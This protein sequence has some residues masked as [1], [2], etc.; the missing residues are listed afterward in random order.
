MNNLRPTKLDDIVGQEQVV[1][2]LNIAIN[3]AKS[4][5]AAL[6]H[7]LF[8]GGPGLGKTSLACAVA[9]TRGVNILI[10][11]GGNIRSIKNI[12]PYLMKLGEN[13]ILFIDEIHR[14]PRVVE[15]FL[16]PCMEDFRMDM[17]DDAKSME[18]P[19]FTMIGATTEMGS[20]ARPFKDRFTYQFQLELYKVEALAKI[21]GN[22]A[23]KLGLQIDESAKL[24]LARRSRGTPRIANNLI[25][26]IRDYCHSQGQN[27]V[28]VGL[29]SKAMSMRGID[30]NGVTRQDRKYLRALQKF[31]RPVGLSTISDTINLDTTTIRDSIEPFLLRRGMIVRTPKGRVLV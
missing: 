20:L 1:E 23:E 13:D 25:T 10:A 6:P 7:I 17:G 8:D 9:N 11:N 26:W 15:E 14:L 5:N 31:G 28:S 29:L 21:I 2:C 18:L 22:S 12:L 27:S 3:S 4:R 19:R 24:N 30:E 16:Y